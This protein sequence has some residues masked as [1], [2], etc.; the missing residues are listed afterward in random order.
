M[1]AGRPDPPGSLG[2][3]ISEALRGKTEAKTEGK[4]GVIRFKLCAKVI[5]TRRPAATT[6][7]P[8]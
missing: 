5:S 2:M 1:R 7:T 3:A 4:R 6:L 8:S